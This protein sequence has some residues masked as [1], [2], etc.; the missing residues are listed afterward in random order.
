MSPKVVVAICLVA[1]L[2]PI[3]TSHAGRVGPVE[4]IKAT[5]KVVEGRNRVQEEDCSVRRVL[6]A[7]LDYI[8]TQGTHN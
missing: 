4:P 2:L 5:T 8:Y 3:R 7:H 6:A 1:L